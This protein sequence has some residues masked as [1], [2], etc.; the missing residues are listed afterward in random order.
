MNVACAHK[1]LRCFVWLQNTLEHISCKTAPRVSSERNERR[2]SNAEPFYDLGRSH[3]GLFTCR[4]CGGSCTFDSIIKPNCFPPWN[5][6]GSV[7]VCRLNEGTNSNSCL[8]FIRMTQLDGPVDSSQ[9][10]K[11]THR[12][13]YLC[14]MILA[15]SQEK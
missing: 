2:R 6:A 5:K 4:Q 13:V 9:H 8:S 10:F 14:S 7:G 11:R 12:F 1:V 15:F 3:L